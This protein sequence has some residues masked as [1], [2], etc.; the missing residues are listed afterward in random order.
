MISSI[1]GLSC[2]FGKFSVSL[3]WKKHITCQEVYVTSVCSVAMSLLPRCSFP[4]LSPH[5]HPTALSSPQNLQGRTAAQTQLGQVDAHLDKGEGSP[6]EEGLV[7]MVQLV[8][9]IGLHSLLIVN[10]L[11]LLHAEERSRGHRDGDGVL[12]LGLRGE[13]ENGEAAP[14]LSPAV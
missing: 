3:S 11:L 12:G 13:G 4:I 10:L 7:L 1:L 9:H 8:F 14:V 6:R 2:Q 5:E